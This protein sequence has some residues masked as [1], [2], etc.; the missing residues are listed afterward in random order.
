MSNPEKLSLDNK[1]LLHD[2][3]KCS[4]V[5]LREVR[6]FETCGN[7]TKTYFNG[8]MLLIYK[9]LNYLESRLSERYFFRASRQYIVNLSH[10]QDVQLLENSSYRMILSCGKKIDISRRRSQLFRQLLSI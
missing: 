9:T 5:Q 10:V 1:V 3:D 7:Y 2:G 8:G 4:L 6:F